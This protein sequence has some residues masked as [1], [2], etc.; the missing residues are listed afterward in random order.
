MVKLASNNFLDNHQKLTISN[1]FEA[2]FLVKI[3]DI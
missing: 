1:F 2:V 3:I